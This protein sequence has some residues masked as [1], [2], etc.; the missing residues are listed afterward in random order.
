MEETLP[1]SELRQTHFWKGQH[2]TVHHPSGGVKGE[3]ALL[4]RIT[5]ETLLHTQICTHW[6]DTKGRNLHHEH[7]FVLQSNAKGEE[8]RQGIAWEGWRFRGN[9]MRE[10]NPEKLREK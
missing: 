1:S 9:A 7:V 10:N 8:S 3:L 4:L 6:P 2:C 5:R